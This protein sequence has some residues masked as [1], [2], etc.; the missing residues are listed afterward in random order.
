MIV[1]VALPGDAMG[2]QGFLHDEMN[3]HDAMN[4]YTQINAAQ[5][6]WCRVQAV[7]IDRLLNSDSDTVCSIRR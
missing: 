3:L 4:L 6:E 1:Y 7:Q 5:K 2:L